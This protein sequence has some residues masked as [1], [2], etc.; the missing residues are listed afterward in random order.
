ML[1]SVQKS[2]GKENVKLV[3]AQTGSEDF[4]YF[5]EKVP[6]LFFFLGGAPKG[7]KESETSPHHTPDFQID[8]GGFVLG[9][10]S[11]ASLVVDYMDAG[12]GK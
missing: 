3:P 11:M 2:A 8:E 12:S 7:K 4:S 10:K 1:P 5:A 6:G 9:M